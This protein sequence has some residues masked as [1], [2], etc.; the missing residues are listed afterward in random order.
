MKTIKTRSNQRNTYTYIDAIGK[1]YTY[2]PGDVDPDTGY[3]LT[4]EDIKRL[5]RMDDN[6]VYNNVKN[7]KHPI[8]PWEKKQIEEWKKTHPYEDLPSRSN[9]S[10]DA[11]GED[12]EG[13]DDDADK[14]YLGDASLAVVEKEDPV[15]ERLHE[16]VAMLRPDQQVLYRRA[17]VEEIDMCIIAEEEGIDPSA[18]RHRMRTIREFIKKNF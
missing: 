17:V 1:K 10:L 7:S 4:E 3:A 8:E 13:V 14:G 9:V 15:I 12:A 5:H 16:V 18:I 6:E 11:E 2:K